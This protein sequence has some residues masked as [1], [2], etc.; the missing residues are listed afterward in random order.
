MRNRIL[1]VA[2]VGLVQ[3]A[4]M[5]SAF[6]WD[7]LGYR[8]VR[9]AV[10]HDTI[11][12]PGN[13]KFDRIKVCAYRRQVHMLDLKVRFANGGSQDVAVRARLRPGTCTRNID[14]V[15]DDRNITAVDMV[16]EANTP[17][18]GVH[19]AVRLFGE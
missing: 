13:R 3:L 16:Y 17:R 4:A 18:R 15:G 11:S 14:L 12:L 9:D 5:P 2:V 10:D 19:A 1:A 6:A 8:D 7:E